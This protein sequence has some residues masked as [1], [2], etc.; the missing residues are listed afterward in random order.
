V[1]GEES[2][3]RI[4]TAERERAHTALA[5]HFSQGR[6]DVAEFEE[7]SGLVAASRTSGDLAELF[8]D[9]PGGMPGPTPTPGHELSPLRRVPEADTLR[10]IAIFGLV[11]LAGGGLA[12]A[13]P[14]LLFL[15]I[16]ISRGL[17]HQHWGS[18]QHGS[19]SQ[20]PR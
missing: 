3:L 2:G 8:L 5:E 6:L 4:G 10:L 13:N 12:A 17:R 7:R 1:V 9:L 19:R 15:L 20:R 16:P 14:W 18:T 11:V